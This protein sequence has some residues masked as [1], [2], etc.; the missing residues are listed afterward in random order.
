MKRIGQLDCD[1][2]SP[3]D[4]KKKEIVNKLS[5]IYVCVVCSS[6][7]DYLSPVQESIWHLCDR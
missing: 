7:F 1:K 4:R 5:E 3:E 2:H 6:T